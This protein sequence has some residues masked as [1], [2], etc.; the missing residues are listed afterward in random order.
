[1]K[2][3]TRKLFRCLTMCMAAASAT[4]QAQHVPP[5]PPQHEVGDMSYPEMVKMMEMDDRLRFGKVIVDQ[6]EFRGTDAGDQ[7]VWDAEAWYGGDI[8]KALIRTEGER[9]GSET[10]EARVELFWDRVIGRWWTLQAGAREDLGRGP[11][12]TWA[13]VG[14]AGRSPLWFEVEA[15]LYAGE[16][17]RTAARIK[18]ERDWL[19]T[20]KLVLQPELEANLYGKS[21]RESGIGSGLSDIDAGLRLRYEIR[22]E[23]APYV[24]V[25]W[26][27]SFGS[28][29]DFARAEGEDASDL[30]LLAGIRVWF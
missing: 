23:V 29:A 10:E 25:A 3:R 22:R 27:R 17:G 1:M 26:R 12:R 8:N 9:T 11:S 18:V 28:T 16:Q 24:G 2:Q 15:T 4:S 7:L 20:Q 5:D 14:V 19:L 13:A 21:D 30:Q 6:A